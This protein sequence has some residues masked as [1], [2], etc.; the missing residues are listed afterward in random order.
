MVANLTVSLFDHTDCLIPSGLESG[1]VP[2]SA[3]T[4]TSSYSWKHTDFLPKEARLW[5]GNVGWV[6][7][8]G[9]SDSKTENIKID[10]GRVSKLN[11]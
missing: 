11:N 10:L 9:S 8:I 4:A 3:I 5:V 2:D 7:K 6:S 1:E